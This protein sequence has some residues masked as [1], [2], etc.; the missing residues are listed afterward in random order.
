M[1]IVFEGKKDDDYD[2]DDNDDQTTRMKAEKASLK[3]ARALQ[4]SEGVKAV[5]ALGVC[6]T[7]YSPTDLMKMF[8]GRWLRHKHPQSEKTKE[9]KEGKTKGKRKGKSGTGTKSLR[10]YTRNTS[11]T[12]N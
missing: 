2:D 7:D 12:R 6:V 11:T 4:Y 1:Y 9:K 10:N 3:Y 8:S 5:E